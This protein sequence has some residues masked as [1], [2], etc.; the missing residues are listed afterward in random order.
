MMTDLMQGVSY[1]SSRP[2]VDPS[3]IGAMGY[4][5]GSFVVALTGAVE[6]R[7][8]ACVL[9]GG[10]NIDGPGGY[11]D[12]SK[13][14]CQGLPYQALNFL[15]DRPAVLYTLHALRGATLVYNGTNDTVVAVPQ[16][17]AE[18]FKELQGRVARLKGDDIH[19]FDT[20]FSPGTSHRPYFVTKPVALWLDHQLDFPDWTETDIQAMPE[21]RIG[22]WC[23]SMA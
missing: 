8:R 10:G 11:W 18:F 13:P 12:G 6:P 2:E 22:T 20:G 4:S 19:V 5:M 3:R 16:Q 7:L 9:V 17:G 1:L 23:R 21:T 14:M 15:G